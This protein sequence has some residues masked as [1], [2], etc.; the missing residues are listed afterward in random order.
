M[1]FGPINQTKDA[2]TELE[3]LKMDHKD[4]IQTYI[5]RFNKLALKTQWGHCAL[6]HW[7]YM[8]LLDQIQSC[9]AQEGKLEL[10]ADMKLSAQLINSYYWQ[11]QAKLQHHKGSSSGSSNTASS[12]LSSSCHN[13]GQAASS[14]LST[15]SSRQQKP[16]SGS[17]ASSSSLASPTTRGLAST[18]GSNG[19]LKPEERQR[20]INQKLCLFCGKPNHVLKDCCKRLAAV[21]ARASST[22]PDA[23]DQSGN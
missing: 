10:L 7:F 2:K 20:W 12:Q 16:S 21:S 22:V 15:S 18:L 23:L 13:N 3:E 17:N 6:Q 14:S 11:R 19:K 8:G 4:K 5:T 9:M 1:N